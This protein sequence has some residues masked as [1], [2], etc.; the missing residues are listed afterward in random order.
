MFVVLLL[1]LL[2]LLLSILFLVLLVGAAAVAGAVAVE[3]LVV[4]LA[5]TAGTPDG[6][7]FRKDG[8]PANLRRGIELAIVVAVSSVFGVE[9]VVFVPQ[10]CGFFEKCFVRRKYGVD[11]LHVPNGYL[12]VCLFPVFSFSIFFQSICS[13]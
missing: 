9:P 1:L 5:A 13:S 10:H 11:S 4:V 7:E 6:H 12:F 2:L 8:T 3:D